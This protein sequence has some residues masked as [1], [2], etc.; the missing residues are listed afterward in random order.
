M[1][2]NSSHVLC[3]LS[4]QS[5]EILTDISRCFAY[6]YRCHL[7]DVITQNHRL[8]LAEIK[9]CHTGIAMILRC[10]NLR[11]FPEHFCQWRVKCY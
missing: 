6:R 8:V 2:S 7:I 4:Y 9:K 1:L 10:V 3:A 11:Y 5:C